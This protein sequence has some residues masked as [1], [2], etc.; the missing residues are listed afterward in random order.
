M[1]QCPTCG[2]TKSKSGNEF[3]NQGQLNLHMY[4]CKMKQQRQNVQSQG[5]QQPIG[6]CSHN[7]RLLNPYKDDERQAM[8]ANFGEVCIKCQDLR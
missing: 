2:T 1:L 7:W 4:H 8:D 5:A 3:T 6:S